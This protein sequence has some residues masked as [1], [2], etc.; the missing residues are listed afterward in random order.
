MSTAVLGLL[1]KLFRTK[2]NIPAGPRT[3]ETAAGE[4]VPGSRELINPG[5]GDTDVTP[6]SRICPGSCRLLQLTGVSWL[7]TLRIRLVLTHAAAFYLG[8]ARP[9]SSECTPDFLR[10]LL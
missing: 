10:R 5:G 6:S 3:A 2:Q 8:D 9:G 7:I 4:Q 1:M